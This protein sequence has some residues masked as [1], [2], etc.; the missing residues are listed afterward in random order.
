M[1]LK[2]Q[3]DSMASQTIRDTKLSFL[4]VL[5]LRFGDL[6][7]RVDVPPAQFDCSGV[8]STRAHARGVPLPIWVA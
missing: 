1:G 3:L 6:N 8:F 5:L 2:S 4:V 7:L